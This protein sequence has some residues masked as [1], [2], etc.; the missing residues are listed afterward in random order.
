MLSTLHLGVGSMMPKP[1]VSLQ[2]YQCEC[3]IENAECPHKNEIAHSLLHNAVA[4][5]RVD[6]GLNCSCQCHNNGVV[7]EQQ[8]VQINDASGLAPLSEEVAVGAVEGV[9]CEACDVHS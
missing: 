5:T 7:G 9:E 2:G 1:Y 3:S 8:I 4:S 6:E